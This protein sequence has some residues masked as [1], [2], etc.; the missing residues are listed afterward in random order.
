MTFETVDLVIRA[1]AEAT[2]ETPADVVDYLE[3]FDDMGGDVYKALAGIAR[4]QNVK[5][6][7]DYYRAEM[8]PAARNVP[9]TESINCWAVLSTM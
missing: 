5:Q 1:Y 3:S 2:G 4:Y 7:L 6:V 9:G 8:Y